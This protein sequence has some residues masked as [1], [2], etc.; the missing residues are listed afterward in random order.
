M[1]YDTDAIFGTLDMILV[2]RN[3]GQK[4][5]AYYPRSTP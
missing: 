4:T 3:M 1:A 5:G 2:L